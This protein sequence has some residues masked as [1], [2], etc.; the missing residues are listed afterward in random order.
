[1]DERKVKNGPVVAVAERR[2]SEPIPEM[3]LPLFSAAGLVVDDRDSQVLAFHNGRKVGAVWGPAA[4][5][6]GE[7]FAYRDGLDPV[8]VASRDDGLWLLLPPVKAIA[9]RQPWAKAIELGAKNTENRGKSTSHRGL[10]A[11][12]ASKAPD[13]AADTDPR[14]VDLL[15]ADP[16]L[17]APAGA[18]V[19]VANLTDC[20][21]A[22]GCCKPWGESPDPDRFGTRRVWHLVLAEV[23]P[24]AGPV[25]AKGALAVPFTL[26][27]A[28]SLAVWRELAEVDRG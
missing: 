22:D 24:L 20:H 17:G 25:P 28:E 3:F 13:V 23:W 18:V 5:G 19:A 21:E 7:W 4:D 15:G 11:I 14:I 8:R 2:W 27:A 12:L 1:M 6:T 16:R 10:V 9:V 26:T